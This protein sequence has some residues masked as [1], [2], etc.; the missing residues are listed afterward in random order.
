MQNREELKQKGHD[1]SQK[2]YVSREGE[3]FPFSE[4]GDIVF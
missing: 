4:G 1:G 2:N 3:K